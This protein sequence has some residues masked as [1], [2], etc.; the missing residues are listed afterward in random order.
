MNKLCRS[1]VAT[2]VLGLLGVAAQASTL[3]VNFEGTVTA[4]NSPA[5]FADLTPLALTQVFEGTLALPD[6]ENF[7][8]GRHEIALNTNGIQMRLFNPGVLW[9]LEG[10]RI[11]HTAPNPAFDP[12]RPACNSA[13][14]CGADFNP[15]TISV[16]PSGRGNVTLDSTQAGEGLLTLVDG[17]VL[18]FE[19]SIN[20]DQGLA[21]FDRVIRDLHVPVLLDTITVDVPAFTA[22][23]QVGD[24]YFA[25]SNLGAATINVISA[26]PEPEAYALM[27]AGLGVVG[28]VARRRKEAAAA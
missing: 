13:R 16:G 7:S 24:V 3:I 4:F 15:E 1:V 28:F 6:F 21:T 8:V 23:V 12:T 17:K 27:L 14:L 22:N 2:G 20:R 11:Q 9:G 26:V 5:Q 25:T 19:Y 10:T 18:S